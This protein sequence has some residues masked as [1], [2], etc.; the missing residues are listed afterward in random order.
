M[1]LQHAAGSGR[2]VAF[3]LRSL[4]IGRN[5]RA[6]TRDRQVANH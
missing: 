2:L 6:M 1:P 3:Q 5:I 4:R